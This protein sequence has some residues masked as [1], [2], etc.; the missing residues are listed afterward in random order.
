MSK[1]QKPR[2]SRYFP[3]MKV[4]GARRKRVAPFQRAAGSFDR[5]SVSAES[6]AQSFRTLIDMVNL[7]EFGGSQH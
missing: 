7:G 3:S 4:R 5:L 6:A 2:T 1:G